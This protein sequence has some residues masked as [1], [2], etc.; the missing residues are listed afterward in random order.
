VVAGLVTLEEVPEWAGLI[1]CSRSRS[2]IFCR[3]LKEAP[4][5]HK[6]KCSPEIIEGAKMCAYYRM[7]KTSLLSNEFEDG[8]GI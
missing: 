1:E 6:K 7:H 5:L 2:N 8:D 3:T 4:K